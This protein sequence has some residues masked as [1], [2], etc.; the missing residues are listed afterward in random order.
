MKKN[1]EANN[2]SLTDK[3]THVQRAAGMSAETTMFRCCS[4][5]YCNYNDSTILLKEA[6]TLAKQFQRTGIDNFVNQQLIL[7]KVINVHHAP[8]NY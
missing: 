2:K 7:L 5:A 1:C 3:T 8:L 6:S 4:W